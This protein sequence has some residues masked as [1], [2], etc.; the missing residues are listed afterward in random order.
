MRLSTRLRIF[1]ARPFYIDFVARIF[2]FVSFDKIGRKHRKDISLTAVYYRLELTAVNAIKHRFQMVG[3][4]PARTFKE[5]L[6]HR[7]QTGER[8]IA[9]VSSGCYFSTF[10]LVHRITGQR[11]FVAA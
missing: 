7:P 4:S 8:H 6:F 9:A 2:D 1:R 5:R 11:F 3:E 10:C